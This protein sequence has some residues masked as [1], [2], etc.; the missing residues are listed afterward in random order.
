MSF[1]DTKCNECGATPAGVAAIST[2]AKWGSGYRCPFRTCD[3]TLV[4]VAPDTRAVSPPVG[5]SAGDVARRL[6]EALA[7]QTNTP[8]GWAGL[9][10]DICDIAYD[11]ERAPTGP[12]GAVECKC[13]HCDG[14]GYTVGWV[15]VHPFQEPCGECNSTGHDC[16]R[17]AKP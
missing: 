4:E 5:P 1:T 3:G 10:T 6:R 12:V 17:G 2:K 8:E 7:R 16:S 11:I 9:F 15:E 14:R 13:K